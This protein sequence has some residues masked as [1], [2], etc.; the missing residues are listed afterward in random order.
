M[1]PQD[2]FQFEV[3]FKCEAIITGIELKA[4][5]VSHVTVEMWN[6]GEKIWTGHFEFDEKEYKILKGKYLGLGEKAQKFD[7]ALVRLVNYPEARC[8]VIGHLL[9]KGFKEEGSK[10][11]QQTKNVS[12]ADVFQPAT[13]RKVGDQEKKIF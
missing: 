5:E 6:Q 9:F 7:R 12:T 4:K 2:I 10:K 8:T 13:K 3:Q 1:T 11:K